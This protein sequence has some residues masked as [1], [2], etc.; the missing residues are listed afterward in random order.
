MRRGLTRAILM[1]ASIALTLALG[2]LV[3]RALAPGRS[4]TDRRGLHEPRPDRPW[5]Y[6]MRPGAQGT[7][8]ISGAEVLYRINAAGFRDHAHLRPKPKGVFRVIVLGDSV[9][10]GYGVPLAETFP[11]RMEEQ[12]AALARG[13]GVGGVEVLSL[14][15]SGYN[16]YTQA[17]LLRDLGESYA[18]DLV[19]VQFCINDLNDPTLHFDAQTRL[20]LGAIPDL[21]Y[22]D[23]SLRRP[24]P[25]VPATLLRGCRRSHVC[26]LLDDLVLAMTAAVPEEAQQRAAAVPV[27]GDAG[28]EW[29]WIEAQYL[30]I[31]RASRRLGAEFA[32]IA[33][34]YPAQLEGRGDHP[35]QRRLRELG[36]RNQWVTVDPLERFRMASH[37]RVSLF[38]DWW[39]PTPA[40][41]GVAAGEILRQLSCGGLLPVWAGELC[42]GP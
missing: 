36:D 34:P 15:V 14:A 38:I 40:G 1:A 6:G 42:T 41:H 4:A 37:R 32:V 33:F 31:A 35:V 24:A 20:H 22:P 19:L 29:R 25:W 28:P 30:D 18:P 17:E 16:P 10:F 11:K 8:E 3:L 7:L 21:A 27:Q 39:H 12:L 13:A 9:A 5:L 2:E 23:P 26:S